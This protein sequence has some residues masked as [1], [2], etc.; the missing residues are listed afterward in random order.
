MKSISALLIL[1]FL[2]FK[3]YGQIKA[4]DITG[5]WLNDKGDAHVEIYQKGDGFF[6]KIIWLKE[7]LTASG[8]PKIDLNNPK[9]A[10]RE[11]EI[12]GMDIISNLHFDG[13]VWEDGTIYLPKKGRDA[14]CSASLS[15]DHKQ[16]TLHVTKLWF[17]T[18]IQWTKL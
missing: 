16:L 12:L 10:L 6:G 9:K 15:K 1:S 7:P 3:S 11:R 8:T 2:A 5:V 4:N 17:S 14:D 13:K 18:S